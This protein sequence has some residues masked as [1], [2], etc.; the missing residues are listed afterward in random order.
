[1]HQVTTAIVN[2]VR[3]AARYGPA[4]EAELLTQ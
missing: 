2:F 4:V 3:Q 1:M